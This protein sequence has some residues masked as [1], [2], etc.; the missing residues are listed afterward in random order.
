MYVCIYLSRDIGR[1][2]V[3]M[4]L[5]IYACHVC[6]H[7]CM[8]VC[9]HVHICVCVC[10]HAALCGEMIFVRICTHFTSLVDKSTKELLRTKLGKL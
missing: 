5:F 1:G 4:Y 2:H 6:M 8:Y 3:C 9:M 7:V 10:V